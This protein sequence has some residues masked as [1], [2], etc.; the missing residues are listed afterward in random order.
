MDERLAALIDAAENG[1]DC[2]VVTALAGSQLVIGTPASSRS[3]LEI[4]YWATV[5]HK[6][7]GRT[8]PADRPEPE[9]KTWERLQSLDPS[10]PPDGQRSHA[11]TLQ[12]ARVSFLDG[13]ALEVPIIRLPLAAVTAWWVAPVRWVADRSA[14]RGPGVGV[15]VGVAIP[16]DF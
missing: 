14:Q 9:A 4:S 7:W 11:L 6:P 13:S 3:F 12:Y 8:K 15:G 5:G 16:L 2:P 1:R 10:N